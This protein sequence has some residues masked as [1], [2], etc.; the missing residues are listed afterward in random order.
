MGAPTFV[1]GKYGQALQFDGTD[2]VQLSP[3][4]AAMTDFTVAAWV[5]WNGGGDWQRIFDFGAG[6][7]Q[8]LIL[9]PSSGSRTVQVCDLY[10]LANPAHPQRN[11][12]LRLQQP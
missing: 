8:Y 4:I 2:Y 3:R 9:T 5:W 12:R 6:T 7:R 11:L 1:P 10:D